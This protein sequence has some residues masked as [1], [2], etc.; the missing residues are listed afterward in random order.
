MPGWK[1]RL[2]GVPI[3]GNNWRIRI[4]VVKYC[5]RRLHRT[6]TGE[7]RNMN[8]SIQTTIPSDVLR[9]ELQPLDAI[10]APKSVAVIGATE[11]PGSVGRTILWNL[12]STPFG[13]TVYPVNP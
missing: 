7:L 8:P 1:S 10:F 5:G 6:K 4:P 12:I 3:P 11:R 2:P 9:G 13:G